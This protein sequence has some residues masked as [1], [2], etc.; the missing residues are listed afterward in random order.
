MTGSLTSSL[1]KKTE[2]EHEVQASENYRQRGYGK[3]LEM[4]LSDYG[5]C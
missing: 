1:K 2:Y 5:K 3:V 4:V